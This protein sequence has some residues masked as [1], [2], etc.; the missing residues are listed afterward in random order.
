MIIL[1][2]KWHQASWY[3]NELPDDWRIETSES[4]W[5][6]EKL[7]LIWLKEMFD[8]GT[9]ARTIGQYRLLILDRHGSHHGPEFD[10]F[11]VENSIIPLY[12]PGHSSHLLQ[13]LDVGCYSP[14]KQIYKKEVEK[15][16]R[17]GINH[18]DKDEFLIIYSSVR[19]AV[20]SE[21]NIQS[22]FRATELI[23]YDPEQVLS[24]LN[25]HMLIP[26]PL[27]TSHSSQ[28]SWAIATPH[29]VRQLELESKKIKKYLK[30]CTQ[31]PP[32]P[33]NQALD[34]LI[35]GCQMA[36]HS[37]AILVAENKA[38]RAANAKQKRKQKR[39]RMYISREEGLTVQEG[40][41][42]V[43]RLNEEQRENMMSQ[44]ILEQ[45]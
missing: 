5:T 40:R 33:T 15:Q 2:G 8:K 43:R 35:N 10:Q 7:G 30:C 22:G 18:I 27:G 3:E 42:R 19:P 13:P 21:K 44:N 45:V 25:T 38:S 29:N 20:L 28:A 12:M 24:Q 4:G 23:P 26:T 9:Q 36:M 6:N 17:L 32:S 11:W 34:Q 41:D 31:S 39:R 1:K 16:M 37:A 14:L